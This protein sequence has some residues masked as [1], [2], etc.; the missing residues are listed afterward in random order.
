MPFSAMSVKGGGSEIVLESGPIPA[1]TSVDCRK[2]SIVALSP[3]GGGARCIRRRGWDGMLAWLPE[4]VS[5]FG[6]DLDSIFYLIYYV[7]GIWFVAT[8]A[9]LIYFLI[10]Y[11][12][13]EGRRAVHAHGNTL[14]QAAWILIPCALVL[15]LDLW[16]D[17]R[18]AEVWAKIKITAPPADQ[19]VELTGK[20]FNW[21]IRY[22]GPDGRF[23]TLDD[24]VV[25]N[26]M[27]VLV[28][29][30]V[31]VNLKSEDV[32]HSFFLPNLRLKQDVVPGREIRAWFRAT[33]T[34]RYSMP[35]AELCGFGHS[36]MEGQLFVHSEEDYAKWT[37]K[38]WPPS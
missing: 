23:E 31:H 21:S 2:V 6:A 25:Q 7:V 24:K 33:K 13:R 29:K 8:E 3:L 30:V 27:H 17:F 20:Q 28:N 36:G 18:G 15:V 11:R 34:G 35:C 19:R 38:V 10:R 12:H 9:L 37:R 1:C 26:E 5:S 4:N 32:I 16:I 14:R 22:P